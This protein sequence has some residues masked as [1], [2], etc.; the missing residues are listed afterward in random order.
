M[1]QKRAR[2]LANWGTTGLILIAVVLG[3]AWSYW[4]R[5]PDDFG[6]LPFA[7]RSE[8]VST[9]SA[10]GGKPQNLCWDQAAAGYWRADPDL[11][12]HWWEEWYQSSGNADT[13]LHP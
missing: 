13:A 2:K 7:T 4:H 9:E 12:K 3:L 11:C 10:A 1:F 8:V 6:R 5:K